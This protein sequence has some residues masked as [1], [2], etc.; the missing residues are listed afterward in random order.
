[1]TN[2]TYR[3]ARLTQNEVMRDNDNTP[4]NGLNNGLDETLNETSNNSAEPNELPL[5]MQHKLKHARRDVTANVRGTPFEKVYA[6]ELFVLEELLGAAERERSL[7]RAK[8]ALEYAQTVLFST[9]HYAR[10]TR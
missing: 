4:N 3:R 1:M 9:N 8:E 7:E 6:Y 5:Y 2:D 10:F